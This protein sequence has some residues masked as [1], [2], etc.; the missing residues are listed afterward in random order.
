MNLPA[1]PHIELST[2]RPKFPSAALAGRD[3]VGAPF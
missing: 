2:E 3:K 1:T